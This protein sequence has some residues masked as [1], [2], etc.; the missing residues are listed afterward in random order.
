VRDLHDV[1]AAVCAHPSVKQ[2][3]F[4]AENTGCLTPWDTQQARIFTADSIAPTVAG[5][6][7]GGGRNPAGLLF[8]ERECL[9]SWDVQSRRIHDESGVWPTLYGGEGGGHGYVA[10]FSAGQGAKAGGIG[11]AENLLDLENSDGYNCIHDLA[12][13]PE[14]VPTIAEIIIKNTSNA[15]DR[16]NFW[17]NAEKNLLSA[18]I[19]Y[20]GSAC[21]DNGNLLPI[22]ERSLGAIYDLLC[23]ESFAAISKLIDKLPTGHPARQPF[24]LIRDIPVQNRSNVVLGLG[25]RLGVF[26]NKKV[27]CITKYNDIDLTL[28]GQ[29]PCCYYVIISD[30]DGSLE[31]L[32][33]MF[34]SL[35]FWRLS[36]YARRYGENGRLKT[37]VNI[38]PDCGVNIGQLHNPGC[39]VERCPRCGGQAISCDCIYETS[40]INV[41]T[42]EKEHP[43]IYKNGPTDKMC[44]K[45]DA[46]WGKRRTAWNGE[47]PGVAE[48]REFGWY[49]KFIEGRGW[50]RCDKDDPDATEDLNRLYTDAIWDSDSQ[51]MKMRK[52]E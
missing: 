46:E 5:A 26:Q 36:K 43:D 22:E 32:S 41:L 16:Q 44:A 42:M 37:K 30:Q 38:F 13:D 21:D 24:G 40:G 35:L 50:V 19:Y 18:L 29:R 12:E 27:D 7:G 52:V 20:M 4:I 39:D 34:F 6:D 23:N 8:E 11:Y 31:F 49:S 17:E 15:K 2:Q 33:S 28:P 14:L 9:T 48:C 3:T 47:W 25:N 51:R 10:A 45:W 1:S